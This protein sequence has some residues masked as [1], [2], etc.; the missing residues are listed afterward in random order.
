[1]NMHVKI[2][3]IDMQNLTELWRMSRVGLSCLHEDL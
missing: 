1:M 3:G 2:E